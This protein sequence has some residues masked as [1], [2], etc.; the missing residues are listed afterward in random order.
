MLVRMTNRVINTITP[1][2]FREKIYALAAR[3]P[4]GKVATYG[5]LAKKGGKPGAARAVGTFMRTNPDMKRVPCHRVVAANGALTGYAFGKGIA[6]KKEKLLEEGVVFVGDSLRA[7]VD[8][9]KS[10]WNLL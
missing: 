9:K 6:T 10:G 7:R 3:I 1:N 8:L 2:S 4:R 5:Q